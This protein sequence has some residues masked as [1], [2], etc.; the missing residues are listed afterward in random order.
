M[1]RIV[2]RSV[3]TEFGEVHS[4]VV[5]SCGHVMELVSVPPTPQ[6]PIEYVWDRATAGG[7]ITCAT[8]ARNALT[9][10][11]AACTDI[12]AGSMVVECECGALREASRPHAWHV[13]GW[14]TP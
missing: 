13:D 4:A 6:S 7:E 9:A 12:R 5:L 11:R 1:S 2:R 14:R 10:Q 8:C 3:R